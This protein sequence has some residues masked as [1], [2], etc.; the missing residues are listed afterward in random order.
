[1]EDIVASIDEY[2]EDEYQNDYNYLF[3]NE[4]M[5]DKKFRT[6]NK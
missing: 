2:K 6:V 1:M 5:P 3:H 4:C